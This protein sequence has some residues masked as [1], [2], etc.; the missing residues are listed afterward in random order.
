MSGLPIRRRRGRGMDDSSCSSVRR[1]PTAR[2]GGSRRAG[3][4]HPHARATCSQRSLRARSRSRSWTGCST[5]RRRSGTTSSSPPS[6]RAWRCSG[7]RAWARSARPS[8]SATAS[9]GWARSSAPTATARSTTTPRWRS[10]TAPRSTASGRSPSRSSRCAPPPRRRARGAAPPPE[11]GA[12]ARRRG[13]GHPLHRAHLAAGAR[14]RA[15]PGAGARAA[16]RVPPARSRSQGGRRARVHRG[17]GRV[18][19][20]APRRCAGA[21]GPGA[22]GA[23]ARPARAARARRLDPA[24]PCARS[25]PARSCAR[26]SRRPDAGTLAAEGLRRLVV[27][28]VAR[29]LGLAAS[30]DEAESAL[31]AWVS[32]AGV[33]PR[34]RDAFLAACGLDAGAARRLGEDA[35][36][37][38]A[39]PRRRRARGAG[40]AVMGGGARAR[41]A[42][43]G[44]L[45]RRGARRGRR[46][47][48]G[49]G[50]GKR[51]R[52][53]KPA[54]PEGPFNAALARLKERLP[55]GWSPPTAA[56]PAPGV[57]AA[58]RP[59]KGP[60][61][62]VVR[63]ERKGRAGKEA[64]VV[65]KLA[66][67]PE[68]LARL[69]GRPEARA[70]LR[71]GG[72]GG[73]DRRCRGTSAS[74]RG[75]GSR[76]GVC[77]R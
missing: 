43:L 37:R 55:E 50:M 15:A 1:S 52:D 9:W 58:P 68:V 32:R 14:R 25:R 45:D 30:P 72:R 13:R 57:D 64:T 63:L 23:V 54:A 4:C 29:S 20:R 3:S 10:C 26:L 69:V 28:G 33:P 59:V 8:S 12:R 7:A 18:R 46:A 71:R 38:G 34:K 74:G 67:P 31:A 41:G 24:R 61:R 36:A 42:A 6:T 66:L 2:P 53:E 70:R 5:R 49:S 17:G 51:E 77:G 65:E 27:A 40:R 39:A 44:G 75:A 48:G 60:A 11:R 76:R 22:A 62:A 73:R 47:R 56:E 35:R 19:A 16:P 21:A